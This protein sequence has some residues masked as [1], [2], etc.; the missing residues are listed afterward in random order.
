MLTIP[1]RSRVYLAVGPTDMR[2]SFD[3]LQNAVR[4]VI[5]RDPLSGHFFV[6]CNRRRDR[7]KILLWDRSGFWVFAKRLEKGTFAWPASD[8]RSVELRSEELSIL[9]G[10]FDLARARRRA[11]YDRPPSE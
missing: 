11:W 5:A 1:P 2:K 8:A 10:G 4:S 3:G 9:L 7:L 6:F